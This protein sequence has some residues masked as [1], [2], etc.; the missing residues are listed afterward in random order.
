MSRGN[1][2]NVVVKSRPMVR[3]VHEAGYELSHTIEEL[4]DMKNAFSKEIDHIESEIDL[5]GMSLY[6]IAPPEFAGKTDKEF[7]SDVE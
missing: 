2:S 5:V 1:N 4:R 6:Q 7:E 3:N